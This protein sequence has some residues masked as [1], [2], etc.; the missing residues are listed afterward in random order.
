MARFAYLTRSPLVRILLIGLSLI[1]LSANQCS[2]SGVGGGVS[3]QAPGFYTLLSQHCY[4]QF[5]NSDLG[6]NDVPELNTR[7]SNAGWN[8]VNY[9]HDESCPESSNEPVVRASMFGNQP[10]SVDFIYF[11]GH[12]TEV[13]MLFLATIPMLPIAWH[14]P[15]P[16]VSVSQGFRSANLRQET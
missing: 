4:P 5:G 16:M 1:I 2:K 9:V 13:L 14:L 6:N 8:L 12:V 11:S 7:L 15:I 3:L 10:Q